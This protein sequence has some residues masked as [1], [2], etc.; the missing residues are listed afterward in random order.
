MSH[1]NIATIGLVAAVGVAF[2]SGPA[3]AIGRVNDF[4]TEARAEYVFACMSSNERN[5]EFLHKCSCAIDTIASRMSY[6]DYVQVETIL[7][8]QQLHTP[9]IEA[10]RSLDVVKEPLDKLFRGEAAAELKCF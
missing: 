6:D 9:N 2:W 4:P 3:S 5:R 10:Y 7:S 1:K 8:L